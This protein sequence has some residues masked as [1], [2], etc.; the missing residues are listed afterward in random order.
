MLYNCRKIGNERVIVVMLYRS[1][2]IPAVGSINLER[3]RAN[4]VKAGLQNLHRFSRIFTVKINR[5]TFCHFPFCFPFQCAY[6][7]LV[8]FEHIFIA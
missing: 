5:Y 3:R 6:S 4:I 2:N 7:F 1:R 8:Q